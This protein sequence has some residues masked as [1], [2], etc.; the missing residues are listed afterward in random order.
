[1]CVRV[2]LAWLFLLDLLC[3]VFSYMNFAINVFV[4][5]AVLFDWIS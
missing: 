2:Y 1:M 5:H 3:G 4:K